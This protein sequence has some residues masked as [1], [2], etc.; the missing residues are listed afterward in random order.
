MHTASLT[1]D[2]NLAK[3]AKIKLGYLGIIHLG[4]TSSESGSDIGRLPFG[5]LNFRF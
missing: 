3:L 1:L 4:G 2:Y 5:S